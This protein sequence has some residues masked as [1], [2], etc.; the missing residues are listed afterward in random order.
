MYN[1]CC[2]WEAC[3]PHQNL[4]STYLYL[5]LSEYKTVSKISPKINAELFRTGLATKHPQEILR[6]FRQLF[7]LYDFI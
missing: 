6:A 1:Y 2:S 5:E 7:Q 3:I 4:K